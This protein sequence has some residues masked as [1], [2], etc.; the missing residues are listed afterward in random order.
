[1]GN[2]THPNEIALASLGGALPGV[3]GGAPSAEIIDAHL[4]VQGTI[5]SYQVSILQNQGEHLLET[6]NRCEATWLPRLT[7]LVLTTWTGRKPR[8]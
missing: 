4:A 6:F 2:T 1:M 8:R 7:L 5:R 3:G